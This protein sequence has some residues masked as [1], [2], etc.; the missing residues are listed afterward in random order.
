MCSVI[1][2]SIIGHPVID[3]NTSGVKDKSVDESSDRKENIDSSTGANKR[4]TDREERRNEKDR[5]RTGEQSE[6]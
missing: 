4:K 3:I 1:K 2:D 6:A 5:G